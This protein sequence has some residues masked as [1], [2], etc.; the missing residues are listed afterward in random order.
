MIAEHSLVVL[1]CNAPHEKL[2]RGDVGTIVHVY[3]GGTR[4]ASRALSLAASLA[5]GLDDGFTLNM[6]GRLSQYFPRVL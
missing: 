2:S 1:D 4:D 6:V 5:N 3:K